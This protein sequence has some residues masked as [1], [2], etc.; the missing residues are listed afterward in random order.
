MLRKLL[1]LP[2]LAAALAAVAGAAPAANPGRAPAVVKLAS[3]SVEGAS[4]TFVARMRQLPD[5]ERMWL[6]FQLLE[7]DATGFAARKAPGLG[8]WRKSKPGVGAFAYRQGVR[9]LE[10]GSLYRAEVRFR[11]YDAKGRLIGATR[12]R[13]RPCRQFDALPNLTAAPVAKRPGGQLGVLRYRVLVTNEGIAAATGVPVRLTV[14][15]AAVDTV[16]VPSLAPAERRVLSIQGPACRS[17]VEAVA[18][19]NGVIVESSEADNAREVSC[20]DLPVS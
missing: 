7:K 19:P 12:R 20:A 17:S 11:W 9:R 15:G 6:R 5:S 16:I 1:I 18:D 2:V 3:C 14:D 4:A 8:R 13:S 10:A